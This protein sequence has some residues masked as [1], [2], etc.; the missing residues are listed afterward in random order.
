M[1]ED[2]RT[3]AAIA[4]PQ[5]DDGAMPGPLSDLRVVEMAGIGPGPFAG[6]VLAD[7]GADIVR[8]ARPGDAGAV[9][10]DVTLR[11]RTHLQA[12]LKSDEGREAVLA[13]AAGADA[14][15]EGFRP[16]VMERL[17]LGPDD[18]LAANRKLVYGRMTGFGQDGPMASMAGHDINYISIAGVLGSM[19]RTGERPLAPLNLVGDYGGGGMLLALG[20]VCAVLHARAT[21]EGQV[22]D[23]AMVDGAALLGTLFHGMRA[24]GMWDGDPGSNLL[25]S[26]APFYDVYETSDARF[27]S[28]GALEP[29][30]YGEL[31]ARLQLPADEWPQYDRERWPQYKQRLTEIF[32]TRTRD[33]WAAVFDGS[34]ACV[35][36]VL[37]MFEAPQHP[38][39]VARTGF[40]EVD[41]VTVPAPAPR[42]GATPS[43]TRPSQNATVAEV[44]ERWNSGGIRA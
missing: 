35:A 41:G 18:L 27:M 11:G 26:G 31:L 12:D 42:F 43:Q 33:E 16:G 17:G 37:D 40:V 24:S 5:W 39:N 29:Q 44:Q 38:N 10:R 36:P 1:L 4:S 3:T 19:R 9:S 21:G 6:M 34:D 14:L 15:I 13:L 23:A 25:D 22:V 7:M 2:A 28:V 8:V 32:K 20:V 30:F